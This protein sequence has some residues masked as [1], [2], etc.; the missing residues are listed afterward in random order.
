MVS[1]FEQFHANQPD[2]LTRLAD[3][4][5][6]K[7]FVMPDRGRKIY[8]K[9]L[10]IDPDYRPA[11][12]GL[13]SL[14]RV[15]I[16]PKKELALFEKYPGFVQRYPDLAVRQAV[17]LVTTG[18]SERGMTIF[19]AEIGRTCG[20]M[21]LF[22]EM[23]EACRTNHYPEGLPKIIALLQ[24][25]CSEDT[26]GLTLAA[27]LLAEQKEYQEALDLALRALE[28]EPDNW[29][30]S[31]EQARALF[32]LGDKEQAYKILEDHYA[33]SLSHSRTNY[34][35]SRMI[36]I[37]EGDSIRSMTIARQAKLHARGDP[38][39]HS[40]LSFVIYQGARFGTAAGEARRAL[41]HSP[42]HPLPHFRRGMALYMDDDPDARKS[43]KKAIELGLW[44]DYLVEAQETLTKL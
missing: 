27:S 19:E 31:A 32:F 26:D 29:D 42:N 2:W 15:E 40:N 11:F 10:E 33:L 7:A 12:D 37:D 24:L 35:L 20:N 44:G 9:V 3:D 18:K 36:A 1:D 30:A 43:L 16:E 5:A 23:A 8:K 39:V 14:R 34:W 28:L 4:F 21:A 17:L 25:Y 13:V 22:E 6:G 41:V 38:Y